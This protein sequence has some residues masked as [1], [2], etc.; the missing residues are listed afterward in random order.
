[1]NVFKTSGN[2]NYDPANDIWS[3]GYYWIGG[4]YPVSNSSTGY[5]GILKVWWDHYKKDN[6]NWLLVS[7]KQQVKNEFKSNY[8]D[9]N[10][11]T[12]EQYCDP[13]EVDYNL[14]ICDE[15]LSN[16]LPKFDVVVCQATLEHLYNPYGAMSNL[17]DRLEVG[18]ICAIHTHLP[19]FMYHP[20]PRDYFRFQPDWFLDLEKYVKNV[21]LLE[22]IGTPNDWHIFALYR[23][24]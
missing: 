18:G 3:G 20:Y 15:N 12:I 5:H 21:E 17:L 11:F 13:S 9:D 2:H 23:K 14:N 6:A 10:F 8:M 1:M 24:I 22:L 19:S 7:E 16:L 4:Y